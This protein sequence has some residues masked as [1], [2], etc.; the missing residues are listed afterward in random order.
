MKISILVNISITQFYRYIEKYFDTKYSWD[1][2]LEKF[3]LN[4]IK[5]NNQHF[6]IVLL[7]YLTII[8]HIWVKKYEFYKYTLIIKLH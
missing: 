3:F 6:K 1:K 2:I 5:S 4:D 8:S 7:I